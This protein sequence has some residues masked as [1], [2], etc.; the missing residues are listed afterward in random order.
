MVINTNIYAITSSQNLGKS[1]ELLGKS[2]ARLSS[3]DKIMKP[4]DDAAGLAV[5]EKMS[6]Q[7]MRV[8]AATN[9][10]QNAISY[11]QTTEGFLK[12]MSGMLNRMSE[13][14]LLAKDVTKNSEDIALYDQEFQALKVQLQTTIGGSEYEITSQPLG[15]FNG[16]SLFGS[17]S[18]LTITI[19]ENVDQTMDI[20]EINLR[21]TTSDIFA[22][23][24][25]STAS[26][27]SVSDTDASQ[28]VIA[29][30]QELATQRASLGA[31]QSRLEVASSQLDVQYENL[32]SAIS[33]IR[34][35][36]VAKESTEYARFQIL[37]QAGTSMLAQA[38]T[39]PQTVLRL[40]Q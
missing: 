17:A 23:L 19:G 16:I 18:G 7:K 22:L 14:T 3:G 26:S 1:Q 40:L 36:D 33:Q 10:V 29:A 4:S 11:V 8:Q 2:L 13:L 25:A 30:I 39:M 37:V 27:V 34:D 12:N 9:N 35:I 20:P 5:S 24:T 32:A 38:N 21:D 31:S 6:A 15:T 28:K